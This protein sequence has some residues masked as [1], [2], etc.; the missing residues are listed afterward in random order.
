MQNSDSVLGHDQLDTDIGVMEYYVTKGDMDDPTDS[1]KVV[2]YLKQKATGMVS[3][4]LDNAMRMFEIG[5]GLNKEQTNITIRD[6]GEVLGIPYP[7]L[8][9]AKTVAKKLDN[10]SEKFRRLFLESGVR[11]F[12]AFSKQL[13]G[14]K[15]TRLPGIKTVET[16][17]RKVKRHIT[18]VK[19]GNQEDMP[20]YIAMLKRIRDL[21]IRNFPLDESVTDPNYIKY[22]PCCCC[23]DQ[24]I[25]PTGN[26]VAAIDGMPHAAYPVCEKCNKDNVPPDYKLVMELYINYSLNMQKAFDMIYLD[27]G[28]DE[29]SPGA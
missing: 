24:D 7:K 8:S 18:A 26:V 25:P 9:V 27:G 10:D 3:A 29:N 16:T 12:E 11:T 23:G 4:F 6:M 14:E 19:V 15:K 21:L 5:A 1:R 2:S 28:F 20:T 13:L 17:H 22:S